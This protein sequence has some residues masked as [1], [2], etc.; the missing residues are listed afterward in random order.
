MNKIL[1]G[2]ILTIYSGSPSFAQ[3]LKP[4]ASLNIPQEIQL[5]RQDEKCGEFGGDKEIIKI[6]SKKYNGEIFADYKK[7]ITNC[8]EQIE[9]KENNNIKLST[10]NLKLA[11]ECI[12]QL[13]NSKLSLPQRIDN[14]GMFNTIV[15]RDST[16]FIRDYPS[17]NWSKFKDLKEAILNK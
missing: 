4:L 9:T 8:S 5:V 11:E 13:V 16:F 3:E 17:I 7:I 14:S 12:L 2:I 6:Y 15:S 10:E 1:I